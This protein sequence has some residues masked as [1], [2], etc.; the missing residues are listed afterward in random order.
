MRRP[1]P[2]LA[3]ALGLALLLL[4]GASAGQAR[5]GEQVNHAGVIVRQADGSFVYGY[6]AFTEDR[7]D[8]VE[9]LRRSGIPLVTTGFGGLGE[10]VCSLDGQGCGLSA[11]RRSVCQGGPNAP[12]WQY[13]RQDG[14]GGWKPLLMGGSGTPVRDGDIDGWSWTAR[15]AALPAITL[16][17]L[18]ALAGVDAAAAAAPATAAW[19]RSGP[20]PVAA[21]ARSGAALAVAGG[22]L[23]VIA[24]GAAAAVRRRARL[25]S[26]PEPEPG[27]A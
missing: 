21:A 14:A 16:P 12:Y 1:A 19:R 15:E 20:A 17:E 24:G 13:F 23:A 18:A 22:V 26:E 3:W 6:V 9:L 27:A 7:I 10:A 8:G 4:A 25:E 5:A 11:C 2:W